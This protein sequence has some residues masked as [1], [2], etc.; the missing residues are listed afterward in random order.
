MIDLRKET[1]ETMVS[2]QMSVEMTVQEYYFFRGKALIDGEKFSVN[3]AS[4]SAVVTAGVVYLVSLGFY[5]E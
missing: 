1:K 2:T 5:I 4:G 3:W